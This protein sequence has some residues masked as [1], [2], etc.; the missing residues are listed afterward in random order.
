MSHVLR[1]RGIVGGMALEMGF[2]GKDFKL[3]NAIWIHVLGR[4]GKHSLFYFT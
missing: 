1:V 2:G 4:G 3:E